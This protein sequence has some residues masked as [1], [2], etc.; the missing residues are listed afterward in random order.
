M[1]A[2]SG[3][4]SLTRLL[5][6]LLVVTACGLVAACAVVLLGDDAPAP[7]LGGAAGVAQDADDADDAATVH[8]S[9][10]DRPP[11]R[12]DAV[13]FARAVLRRWDAARASAWR[14][15]DTDAL[16]ALYTPGSVAGRR[17][18]A[19]LRRWNGRGVRVTGMTVQVLALRVLRRDEQRL[20]LRV[21]DRLVGARA[22]RVTLPRDQPTTRRVELRRSQGTWRVAS[23]L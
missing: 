18:V 23:V 12:Q 22:G 10:S 3:L 8:P 17:D 21:T 9:P 6:A 14:A 13:S 1:H 11:E 20:V 16:A 5:S 15:G 19:M 7:R 4:L 2:S